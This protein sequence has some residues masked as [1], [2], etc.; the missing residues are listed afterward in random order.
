MKKLI[1]YLIILSIFYS[2]ISLKCGENE[3]EGC[4]KCGTGE[5]STKCS[6]CEDKYFLVLDGEKCI[7]CD[8][9]LLAMAGCGGNCQMIKSE[10][11]VL[12]QENSCKEGYYEIYPGTCAICSFLFYGC[13]KCSYTNEKFNCLECQEEDHY[14]SNKY[15]ICKYCHLNGCKKCLNENA[16]EECR[17]GYVLYPNGKCNYYDSRCKKI[18]YSEE[19]EG[20]ICLECNDGYTL[21]P[22]GTCIDTSNCKIS[23]FSEVENRPICSECKKGYA[24]YPNG[25]CNDY[26]YHCKNK[27]YSEQDKKGIC[28]EC[29][30]GYYLDNTN[31]CEDCQY[32]RNFYGCKKCHSENSVLICDQA[33]EGYY[34]TSSGKNI[35]PCPNT[36]SSCKKCSYHTEEDLNNNILKCD[37][38]SSS[39]VYLSSD[40][41]S[42]KTCRSKENGCLICSDN[43]EQTTC[44]K[45][46]YGYGLLS[47]STCSKWSDN[48]GEGCTSC[49]TSPFDFIF[50][51]TSCSDSYTLGNDGKCKH[52]VNDAN[53]IGCKSCE[54]LGINGFKCLSCLDNY[55]LIDGR[56][57]IREDNDEFSTCKEM[58]NIGNN[59]EI[60]YSCKECKNNLYIFAKKDNNAKICV[61]PSSSNDLQYCLRSRKEAVGENNYTCLQCESEVLLEY[62][63]DKKKQICKSCIEGY[64]KYEFSSS[65]D[66]YKCN[67]GCKKCHSD[68]NNN[69]ICDECLSGYIKKGTICKSCDYYYCEECALD[70]NQKVICSKLKEPYFLNKKSEIDVCV[71]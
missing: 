71:N 19:K 56:C 64:Y 70:E 54:A 21:Y 42:C 55:I 12:C 57:Q 10:K 41:R 16:C 47:D 43:E 51:C 31:K 13:G 9:E 25:T 1:K 14:I 7:R 22:N 20:G 3:I 32:Y 29:N 61:E 49:S 30:E 36:I 60:I 65:F 40:E 66:C 39:D 2:A 58:E 15:N 69:V 35:Y 34:V 45:C 26:D 33:K 23:T 52:C 62:D 38:C 37:E 11:N 28:L 44:D 6:L 27:V 67:N 46:S 63:N 53:L 68:E 8:D 5:N 18:E 4:N 48:F 59:E 17:E 24:L 50:Y